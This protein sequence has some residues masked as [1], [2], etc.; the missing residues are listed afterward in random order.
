MSHFDAR[1]E[2]PHCDASPPSRQLDIHVARTHAD[3]PP[4]TARFETGQGDFYTCAFRVGHD[5][6]QYGRWHASVRGDGE[7]TGR[8]VWNDSAKGATPH[9]AP[10]PTYSLDKLKAMG[11]VSHTVVA[12][13]Q[14]TDAPEGS[15]GGGGCARPECGG[16]VHTDPWGT[17]V[18]CP[19]AE[20]DEATKFA[21]AIGCGVLHLDPQ[22]NAIPCPGQ[23][24]APHKEQPMKPRASVVEIVASDSQPTEDGGGSIVVP[25]EVR[26]N[27]VSV[28]TPKGTVVKIEDFA[29]G[30]SLVTVNLTLVVRRLVIG[31]D[32]DLTEEQ[33]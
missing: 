30:E 6:G 19:H 32:G 21:A 33:P 10:E 12:A 15:S 2:C 9:Q 4:C 13:G 14:S 23:Q 11:V 1:E 29:L 3:L 25:R 7:V 20:P 5:R 28:Y 26:I 18:Q 31:A 17:P 8:Y 24:P 27:G 22:G 16:E